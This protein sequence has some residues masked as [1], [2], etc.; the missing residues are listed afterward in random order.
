MTDTHPRRVDDG[1]HP[2]QETGTA[3]SDGDEVLI[4]DRARTL[5]VFDQH[6]RK[7]QSRLRGRRGIAEHHTII[8]LEGNGTEY[9]LLCTPG[10]SLGPMLYKE[11]EWD[12]DKTDKF[13]NSPKYSRSG[14]RVTALEVG[15]DE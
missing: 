1:E 12:D 7:N 15:N 14:E 4:N 13:G 2:C 3:L 10:S 5:T 11:S 6:Q 8:E 9:H